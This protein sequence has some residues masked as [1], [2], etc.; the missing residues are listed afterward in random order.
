MMLQ[1]KIALLV[2]PLAGSGKSLKLSQ[3]ISA[4][5]RQK[6][7][8]HQLFPSQ[9]PEQ[10]QT[11][12]DIWIVGGDGTLN[13]F[14]NRYPSIDLPLSLFKGGTGNDFASTLYG[15]ISLQQQVELVL[16]AEARPVDAGVCNQFLFLN[17]V[18]IGFDGEVLKRMKAIRFIGGHIGYYLLVLKQIFLFREYQFRIYA[19]ELINSGK[20]LLVMINNSG[21]TGGGFH[22]SPKSTV[23][24]GMLDLVIAKPLSILKRLIYLPVIQKGKHLQLPFVKHLTG[25]EFTIEAEKELFAQLDGELIAASRFTFS[26][27]QGK[28]LFRY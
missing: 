21:R 17:G 23:N 22:V 24:D 28:F 25:T 5:L 10:F 16:N 13:Y 7:I 9:W 12:T 4:V 14:I 8:S 18:G 2:N 11:F 26:V 20:Y 1:P 27:L 6:N 19:H 3:R 15:N